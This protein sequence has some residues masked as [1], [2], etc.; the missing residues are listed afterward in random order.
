MHEVSHNPSKLIIAIKRL[1]C[2]RGRGKAAHRVKTACRMGGIFAQC[3]SDRRLI[4]RRYK[5]L[6]ELNNAIS[7]ESISRLMRQADRSQKLGN[8]WPINRK[9]TCSISSTTGEM[10][11]KTALE[12]SSDPSQSAISGKQQMLVRAGTPGNPAGGNRT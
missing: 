3:A 8:K 7:N 11:M 1:L 4:S 2:I 9:Q 6:K 5:E 12:S 10:Q